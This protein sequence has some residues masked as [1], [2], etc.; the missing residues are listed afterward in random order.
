MAALSDGRIFI[1]EQPGRI[2]IL[3][4]GSLSQAP[5]LDLTSKV[6]SGGETG[7][8]GLAFHPQFAQNGR[9]FVNYTRLASGQLQSVTSE[10]TVSATNPDKVDL[11]T[12]RILLTVNKRFGNHNG[13][14]IA[15]GP[16]GFLYIG[17]GD[18]GGQ[19]DPDRNGQNTNTLFGKILRINVDSGSPYGIPAD[20]I[21]ANGGGRS[22]IF[23]LGFRNP[24]RFSFDQPTGRLFVADV[25]EKTREEV[26]I[27]TRG[28]NYGWNRMEGTVCF[29]QPSCD[30][31]GLTPPIHDYGRSDGGTIIGGFVYHGSAIPSLTGAYVFGDFISGRVWALRENGGTWTRSDLLSTGLSITSFG[32]DAAGELYVLDHNGRVLKIAPM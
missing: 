29:E 1:L 18:G 2:R 25:G 17:L 16:D 13:G 24:W 9:L 6:E 7:L 28:G 14:Q 5:F 11:S 30:Q 4:S 8:L 23:A 26:D 20:N 32:Q 22:E 12:E 19:G 27:V 10:F 15:F 3:R 21:F 31:T